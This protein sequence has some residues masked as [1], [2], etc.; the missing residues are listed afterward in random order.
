[1][2]GGGGSAGVGGVVL[3]CFATLEF[4][5]RASGFLGELYHLSHTPQPFY[6]LIIFQIAS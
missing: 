6:A 1:L 5:P 3:F 4:E 2:F